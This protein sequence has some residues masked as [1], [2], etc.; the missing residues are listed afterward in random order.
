[1]ILPSNMCLLMGN[2]MLKILLVHME[3]EIDFRLDDTQY[4]RKTYILALENIIPV[5]HCS[6]D[7]PTQSPIADGCVQEHQHHTERP[8]HSCQRDPD[9]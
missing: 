1:M 6:I 9:L 4:K 5:K 3:R 7:S 8:N 2:Y